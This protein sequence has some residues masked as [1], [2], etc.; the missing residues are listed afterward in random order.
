[1]RKGPPARTAGIGG[2]SEGYE[3]IIDN[4]IFVDETGK[5]EK[6]TE[7][8]VYVLADFEDIVIGR[9][10]E[11]DI[12]LDDINASRIHGVIY[13]KKNWWK[14]NWYIK[15]NKSTYGTIIIRNGRNI[16]V[17]EKEERLQS[18]DKIIMGTTLLRFEIPV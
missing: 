18:K 13:V 7:I 11:C 12:V 1:M 8:P 9:N 3:S 6:I 14:E 2:S 4:I 15:D 5:M 16:S 17:R 10:K